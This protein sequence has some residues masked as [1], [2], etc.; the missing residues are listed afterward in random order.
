MRRLSLVLVLFGTLPARAADNPYI[1]L[2]KANKIR[3]E[4]GS[5]AEY[6][7]RAVPDEKAPQ[8]VR[9]LV[10]ALK[11]GD[12]GARETAVRQLSRMPLQ[13]N[14]AVK[15]ASLREDPET[16]RLCRRILEAHERSR[17]EETLNAVMHTIRAQGIKGLVRP[18]IGALRMDADAYLLR[19][20]RD[21]LSATAT[22]VDIALL[23]EALA[24]DA[25]E[26]RRGAAAALDRVVGAESVPAIRPLLEDPDARV[27]LWAAELVLARGERAALPVLAQLLGAE[28]P[29]VRH[30]AAAILRAVTGRTFGF[31]SYAAPGERAPAAARWRA[32]IGTGEKVELRLPF[33]VEA[34]LRGRTLVC[35][36]NSRRLVDYDRNG[37]QIYESPKLAIPWG[38]M[39]LPSGNR[40]VAVF[41]A[42]VVI[43]Y[44]E[45]GREIW[46]SPLLP[47]PPMSVRRLAN[48]NTL[49][50]CSDAS[51][52]VELSPKG[53]TIWSVTLR[54]WPIDA[55]RLLNGRT[56][57]AC[58]EGNR[59]VEVD[60]RGVVTWELK[61]GGEPAS[62]QRLTNG[63]TLV[64][65]LENPD[66]VTEYDGTG[67]KVWRL[68]KLGTVYDAQRLPNGHTLVATH[69]GVSEYNALG[70][71]VWKLD[72][73][74]CRASRY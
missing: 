3:P 28:R 9:S 31:V 23:T 51:R 5:I 35:S 54:G 6:L 32:H 44:D 39:G 12:P 21:A 69:R 11:E 10:R 29:T 36:I 49:V 55:R 37:K 65:G 74:P 43:E 50:A 58:Y 67:A 18:V 63:N 4:R 2:L 34:E 15:E 26:V 40:L 13:S 20:M 45:H 8:L 52:V 66:T 71:L 19:T 61:G 33:R 42:R 14:L 38:C 22:P 16:R 7:A 1:A 72:V 60:Q 64:A 27:R 73:G 46:R 24:D 53:N 47:G 56:L 59:V 68:E 57:V 70:Q 62:A 25:A 17:A 30:R 48:G 41:S